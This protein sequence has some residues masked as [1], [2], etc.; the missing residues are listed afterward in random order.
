MAAEMDFPPGPVLGQKY[1]APSGIVYEWD[2]YGWVVG[3]YDTTTQQLQSVGDVID[4]IRILLQDTDNS[5]GQY[6]YSTD[7]ILLSL[8]QGMVDLYRMR[9]DIFLSLKFVIPVYNSTEPDTLIGI[10][11]QYISPLV[12]Y[13]VGLVQARDDEQTQDAR[14]AAFLQTFKGAVLTVS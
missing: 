2:G 10:E 12:F 7:S 3:F 9:P 11:M 14:A 8:N 4:Q 13:T 5:S 1:T 6:R